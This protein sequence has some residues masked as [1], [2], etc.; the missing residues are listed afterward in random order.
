M[1]GS[2]L[3]LPIRTYGRRVYD[4]ASLT[5]N[6][7]ANRLTTVAMVIPHRTFAPGDTV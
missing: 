4:G 6:C 7:L 1:R 3:L 5:F 2:D